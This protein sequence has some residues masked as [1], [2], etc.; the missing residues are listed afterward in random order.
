MKRNRTVMRNTLQPVKQAAERGLLQTQ[1]EQV[2]ALGLASALS[3]VPQLLF[4]SV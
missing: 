4:L 3:E 2:S 1:H